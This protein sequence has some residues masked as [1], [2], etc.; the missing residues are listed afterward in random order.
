MFFL[1]APAFPSSPYTDNRG[2]LLACHTPALLLGRSSSAHESAV[3]PVLALS[4]F[5]QW[6]GA[7]PDVV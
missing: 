5:L 1:K 6:A 2:N 3:N 4:A 7:L